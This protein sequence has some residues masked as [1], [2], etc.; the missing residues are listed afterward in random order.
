MSQ[1][2][3][4]GGARAWWR[5]SPE[6]GETAVPRP[7]SSRGWRD[8]VR[9]SERSKGVGR[10]RGELSDALE[11]GEAVGRGKETEGEE[12][13]CPMASQAVGGERLRH[14]EW[15]NLEAH[16]DILT[17]DLIGLIEY[18]YHQGVSSFPKAHL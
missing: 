6:T 11:W 9:C 16:C 5:P 13:G 8:G 15:G 2:E 17:Q 4:G 1:A 10:G 3:R 7:I 12:G 14:V 18:S